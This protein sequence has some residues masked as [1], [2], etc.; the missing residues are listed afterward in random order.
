MSMMKILVAAAAGV[1]LLASQAVAADAALAQVTTVKGSVAVNKGGKVVPVTA[2]TKL[3]AGD[4][5]MSMDGGQAK[6]TFA[7]GCVVDVSANAMAT[8][9]AKSPCAAT[10][11]LVKS[12][13]PM[14]FGLE[15]FGGAAAVFGVG[16]VLVGV[17]AASVDDDI[18]VSVS[19]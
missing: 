14:Q 5:V 18:D 4:R 12:S 1:S 6:I 3:A 2:S 10:G 8:V 17:Y 16:A 7:D 19:P 15:G 13:A 11:G 9:G